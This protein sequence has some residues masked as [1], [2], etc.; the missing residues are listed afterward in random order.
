MKEIERNEQQIDN[1]TITE[2]PESVKEAE[3]KKEQFGNSLDSF[4]STGASKRQEGNITQTET[5]ENPDR[6][7]D[8][9]KADETKS[10]QDTPEA[11]KE[12]IG[13][14]LDKLSTD[15]TETDDAYVN[16]MNNMSDYL[17]K[18]NYGRE[19]YAEYSRDPEWQKL[20]ADLQKSLGM[21]VT[22]Y[23]PEEDKTNSGAEVTEADTGNVRVIDAADIDMTYAQGM[24]DKNFW[25][26]HGNTRE[27]YMQLAE[28]IP[29]VQQALDQGKTLDEIKKDPEL[30][31]TAYAYFVPI[32][33]VKV[34]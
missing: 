24:D 12:A 6:K 30:K 18:H 15:G 8:P 34:E 11:K 9:E 5:K 16:A 19:D 13:S 25:N 20:N 2:T 21:E 17:S 10:T 22:S 7:E 4:S 1:P 28:K 26:H 31:D 27:D 3:Q 23:E 32:N 33:M 29:D 14:K